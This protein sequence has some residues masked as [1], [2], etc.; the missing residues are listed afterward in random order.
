L[1][2][3][4]VIDLAFTDQAALIA[5]LANVGYEGRIEVHDSPVTLIGYGGPRGNRTAAGESSE[6]L[7]RHSVIS[8]GLHAGRRQPLGDAS[9]PGSAVPVSSRLL[10]LDKVR[11][12]P[13]ETAAINLCGWSASCVTVSLT[14][15]PACSMA[16]LHRV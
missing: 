7:I 8:A 2:H 9:V 12:Q 15:V 10:R 1:S 6:C 5:A 13:S 16:N 4:T 14:M 3:Y 11:G